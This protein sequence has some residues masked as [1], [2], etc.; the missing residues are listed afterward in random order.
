MVISLTFSCVGYMNIKI[1]P[2]R[3]DPDCMKMKSGLNGTFVIFIF[4]W[5]IIYISPG[6]NYFLIHLRQYA[7][8]NLYRQT[9]VFEK[10][11]FEHSLPKNDAKDNKHAK[12]V[13]NE[14]L[15]G[16]RK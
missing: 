1:I 11:C 16:Q 10:T 3:Q 12:N 7:W 13:K 8:A 15:L 2:V 6:W 5:D 14:N 4:K 9:F